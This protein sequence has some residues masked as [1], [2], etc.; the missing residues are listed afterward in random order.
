PAHGEAVEQ[1]GLSASRLVRRLQDQRAL[2]VAARGRVPA[3]GRGDRAEAA[4]LPVQDP[5]EA[6]PRVEAREAAPV[7]RPGGRDQRRGVTVPDQAVGRD[8]RILGP[9]LRRGHRL[10][11][12]PVTGEPGGPTP[13]SPPQPPRQPGAHV[14]ASTSTAGCSVDGPGPR[15]RRGR[16]GP[17]PR[18]PTGWRPGPAAPAGPSAG[19]RSR[20]GPDSGRAPGGPTGRP[21]AWRP[22]CLPPTSPNGGGGPPTGRRR[23]PPRAGRWGEPAGACSAAVTA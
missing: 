10:P 8:R 22:C 9:G 15:S 23:P 21:P 3:G 2:H 5:P 19:S 20:S 13:P 6:T 4:A 17:P 12:Q 7:D 14:D 11:P 1:P 18:A 16:R